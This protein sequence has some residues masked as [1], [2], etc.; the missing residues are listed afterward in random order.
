MSLTKPA[1]VSLN[2]RIFSRAVVI[3]GRSAMSTSSAG[4]IS[5]RRLR[6][7]IALGGQGAGQAV[8]RLDGRDDRVTLAVEHSYEL[9]Q[10]LTARA[11]HGPRIAAR[12]AR[13]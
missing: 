13:H 1:A 8:E 4:G 5:S 2:V 3:R 10:Q 9:V 12:S 11:S 7:H 6:H